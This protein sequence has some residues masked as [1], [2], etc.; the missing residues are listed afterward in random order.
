M[1]TA[2]AEKLPSGG[3]PAPKS[4]ATVFIISRLHGGVKVVEAGTVCVIG[5][6]P[7]MVEPAPA[8]EALTVKVLEDFFGSEISAKAC[9]AGKVLAVIVKICVASP[10]AAMVCGAVGKEIAGETTKPAGGT[11]IKAFNFASRSNVV[12]SDDVLVF[13]AFNVYVRVCGK[14]VKFAGVI[15]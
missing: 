10:P 15:V 6:T 8:I 3:V 14:V 11:A 1:T 7:Q 12:E 4:Q 13:V 5:A 9:Q 2:V